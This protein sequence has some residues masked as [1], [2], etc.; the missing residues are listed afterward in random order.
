MAETH[1]FIFGEK[2][3]QINKISYILNKKKLTIEFHKGGTYEYFPILLAMYLAFT[4]AQSAGSFFAKYI[5]NH[6]GTK[7]IKIS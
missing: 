5:K 3:S 1:T 2:S 7:C 6:K 4:K